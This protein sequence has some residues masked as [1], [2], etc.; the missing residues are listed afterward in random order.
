[1]LVIT[2]ALSRHALLASALV[3]GAPG[4]GRHHAGYAYPTL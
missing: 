3:E 4:H 2:N 1:M